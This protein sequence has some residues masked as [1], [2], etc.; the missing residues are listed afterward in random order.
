MTIT[1]VYI[2]TPADA[3]HDPQV[4]LDSEQADEFAT[5]VGAERVDEVVLRDHALGA[6]RIN[7]ERTALE[8]P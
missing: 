5:L 1:Y 8:L 6:E 7:D 4:F 2:V 3:L